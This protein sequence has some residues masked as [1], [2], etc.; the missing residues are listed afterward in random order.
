MTLIN[1]LDDI[2]NATKDINS[3]SKLSKCDISSNGNGTD[4][5]EN[6][7]RFSQNIMI[8]S[9]E[10]KLENKLHDENQQQFNQENL[11]FNKAYSKVSKQDVQKEL[12]NE[13]PAEG[14]SLSSAPNIAEARENQKSLEPLI[15][16][17]KPIEKQNDSKSIP[18]PVKPNKLAPVG[19]TQ[20]SKENSKKAAQFGEKKE[21]DDY[22]YQNKDSNNQDQHQISQAEVPEYNQDGDQNEGYP[23][24][25][26][27]SHEQGNNIFVDHHRSR[28][29]G[30]KESQ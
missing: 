23:N 25:D 13:M 18:S 14:N 28:Y 7:K 27:Y 11:E 9:S 12:K 22:I 3:T 15:N 6:K 30:C 5:I 29:R 1:N 10:T 20:P 24:H 2:V 8:N 17:K 16:S 19:Q 4:L 21:N 26:N